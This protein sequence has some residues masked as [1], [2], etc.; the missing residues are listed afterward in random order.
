[1][2]K[3]CQQCLLCCCSQRPSLFSRDWISSPLHHGG[4]IITVTV[5]PL[6]DSL[7][8]SFSARGLERV[9][10]VLL[11]HSW[12]QGRASCRRRW[13]RR[14]AEQPWQPGRGRCAGWTSRSTCPSNTRR[15]GC[16]LKENEFC[17]AFNA[18]DG[19]PVGCLN[20]PGLWQTS[21]PRVSLKARKPPGPYFCQLPEF[22]L[23]PATLFSRAGRLWGKIFFVHISH[24]T[25][26][27]QHHH[28]L[29]HWWCH[30]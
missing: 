4:V 18:T 6:K 12:V 22:Q 21:G 14:T 5:E 16:S 7:M 10:S 26:W 9:K 24:H 13:T 17:F 1:M 2:P 25:F 15:T 3:W 28:Q 23:F 8:L 29:H 11:P 27:H 20:R 19:L 30:E